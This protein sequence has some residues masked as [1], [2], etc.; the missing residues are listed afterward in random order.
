M[1]NRRQLLWCKHHHQGCQKLPRGSQSNKRMKTE[2]A[3]RGQLFRVDDHC[4][5]SFSLCYKPGIE[6]QS[7]HENNKIVVKTLSSCCK[8]L[9]NAGDILRFHVMADAL[10][11]TVSK[12][13]HHRAEAVHE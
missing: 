4:A 1:I 11:P 10:K 9:P 8:Q 6:R 3:T 7:I 12:R 13:S 2:L 5:A